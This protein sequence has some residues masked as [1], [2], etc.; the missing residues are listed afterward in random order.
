MKIDIYTCR[1]GLGHYKAALRIVDQLKSDHQMELLDLYGELY[2]NYVNL[3]YSAY[4]E[5]IKEQGLFFKLFSKADE[6]KENVLDRLEFLKRRFFKYLDQRELPDIFIATYSVSAYLISKYLEK[7]NLQI[8]LVTCITDFSTHELWVNEKT[9]LYLVATKMTKEELVQKGVPKEKILVYGLCEMKKVKK[10]SKN[11][12]RYHVLISGGGLGILPENL[13]FY[14]VLHDFQNIDF[15]IICGKNKDIYR[16]IKKYENHHIKIYSFVDNMDEFMEWADVILTKAGGMSVSEAILTETP[17]IYFPPYL[18]QEIKNA[19]FISEARIG[20]EL[21][22]ITHL[23]HILEEGDIASYKE[24][25]KA[26]KSSFCPHEFPRWIEG[27][28]AMCS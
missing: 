18:T 19:N 5:M 10:V 11:E 26:I 13:E 23:D 9:S 14:E 12:D 7:R 1:F 27:E 17:V 21:P 15:K 3:I 25:M 24:N 20:R 28:K 4:K 6:S 16:K 2:P 22:S 8:P